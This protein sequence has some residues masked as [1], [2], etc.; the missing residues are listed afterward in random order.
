MCISWYNIKKNINQPNGVKPKMKEFKLR[1][2]ANWMRVIQ[3]LGV[4]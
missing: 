2:S 1:S 3:G 4:Q